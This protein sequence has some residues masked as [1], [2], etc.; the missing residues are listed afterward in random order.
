MKTFLTHPLVLLPMTHL[1]TDLLNSN[2]LQEDLNA[3]FGWAEDNNMFFNS[4]KFVRIHFGKRDY[5]AQYV[6]PDGQL[7]EEKTEAKDLGI[8]F[9]NSL[10]FK[11]HI[12]DII[13]KGQRLA[14][15]SLRIFLSRRTDVMLTLLKSLVIPQMEHGCVVWS[16]ISQNQINLLENVQR[17]FTSRFS[18]FLEYDLARQMLVCNV[19]YEERLRRLGIYSLQRRR[20]RYLIIYVY[21]III[22]MVPNPGINWTDSNYQPRHGIRIPPK[23]P[24]S[25]IT[26]IKKA[27]ASSFFFQ[28]P[29][30]YNLLPRHLRELDQGTAPTKQCVN[31]FKN[32]LDKHL[33]NYRDNPGTQQNALEQVLQQRPPH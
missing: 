16:P 4:G 33:Q 27:R 8:I 12:L 32:K 5:V 13:N 19:V 7:I 28:G 22:G 23:Y 1:I 14:A 2:E 29:L 17:R 6:T 3:V 26:W 18:C 9:D 31:T 15:H 10:F 21:K 25:R 20:E 24:I 30:L 11:H